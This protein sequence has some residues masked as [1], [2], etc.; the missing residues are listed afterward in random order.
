MTYFYFKPTYEQCLESS[1]NLDS[2]KSFIETEENI[3]VVD[4]IEAEMLKSGFIACLICLVT[5]EKKKIYL[6]NCSRRIKELF[7]MMQISNIFIFIKDLKI[8]ES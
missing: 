1:Y 6:I 7:N 2:C 5:M 8:F 4:L 3:I